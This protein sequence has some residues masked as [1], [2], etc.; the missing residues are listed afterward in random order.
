M[1]FEISKSHCGGGSWT[2]RHNCVVLIRELRAEGYKGRYSILGDGHRNGPSHERLYWVTNSSFLLKCGNASLYRDV[3]HP[4]S[5]SPS[6]SAIAGVA[7]R[8]L[9]P[10]AGEDLRAELRRQ[11]RWVGSIAA[12]RNA[13][14]GDALSREVLRSRPLPAAPSQFATVT[15][16][17]C[18]RVTAGPD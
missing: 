2:C 1:R 15:L 8:S 14:V 7:E 6:R 10:S 18:W 11:Q 17:G 13:A 9:G 12:A 16:I 3:R 4:R 5:S